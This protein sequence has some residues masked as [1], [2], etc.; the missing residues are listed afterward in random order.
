MT[1]ALRELF[2][3]VRRASAAADARLPCVTFHLKGASRV[4]ICP[5]GPA[6]HTSTPLSMTAG[7]EAIHIR[8]RP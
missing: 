2:I 8:L 7:S 6:V 4:L 3:L 1:I 5:S